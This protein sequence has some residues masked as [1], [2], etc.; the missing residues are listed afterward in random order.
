MH[1]VNRVYFIPRLKYNR[2]FMEINFT[3]IKLKMAIQNVN[4]M[5]KLVNK[6]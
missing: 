6:K 4:I 5:K 2:S 3:K 1:K